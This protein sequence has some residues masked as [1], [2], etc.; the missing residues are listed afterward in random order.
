ML[1]QAGFKIEFANY[2]FMSFVFPIWIINIFTSFSYKGE[3]I[4]GHFGH[5][6][7]KVSADNKV[8]NKILTCFAYFEIYLCKYIRIPFGNNLIVVAKKLKK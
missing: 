4:G 8:I 6:L 7:G 5:G 1:Q 2:Y 3:S